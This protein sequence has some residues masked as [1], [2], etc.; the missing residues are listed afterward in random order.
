MIYFYKIVYHKVKKR[1]RENLWML[2]E[3]KKQAKTG[4][5]SL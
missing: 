1:A 5:D 4:R 3:Y 2:V